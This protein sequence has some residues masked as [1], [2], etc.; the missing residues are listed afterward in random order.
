[1]SFS[2]SPSRTRG[3]LLPPPHREVFLSH[4]RPPCRQVGPPVP[5]CPPWGQTSRSARTGLGAEARERTL[6]R[7]DKTPVRCSI[8]AHMQ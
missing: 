1:M 7:R 2:S 5:R 4:P 8:L 6:G 3:R